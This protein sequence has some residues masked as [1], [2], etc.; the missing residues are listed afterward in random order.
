MQRRGREFVLRIGDVVAYT[1]GHKVCHFGRVTQVSVDEGMIG[2]HKYRPVTGSL[3]VKWVLSFLNEE[4]A[5]D[6]NGTRPVIERIKL[7]EVVTKADISR[8]GVLGA[9]ASRK[10]DKAGYRLFEERVVALVQEQSADLFTVE[11]IPVPVYPVLEEESS[12][13]RSWLECHGAC[14]VVFLEVH[15]GRGGLSAAARRAGF[16]AAPPLDQV[17]YGRR[18]ICRERKIKALLTC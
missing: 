2:V 1:K 4:G 10:L 16:P 5:V 6:E 12:Q 11:G 7:K 14:K 13:L 15:T 9:S 3:R 17:S 18:G 8:D